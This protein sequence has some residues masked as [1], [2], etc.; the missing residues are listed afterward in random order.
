MKRH[1]I[2]TLVILLFFSLSCSKKKEVPVQTLFN[3]KE[4]VSL[5]KKTAINSEFKPPLSKEWDRKIHESRL[6]KKYTRF[7]R[8]LFIRFSPEEFSTPEVLNG[9]IYAGGSDGNF[10]CLNE[11]DGK[12]IW[13]LPGT[14]AVFGNPF[15]HDNDV[16]ISSN[17]YLWRL[18]SENGKVIWKF[19]VETEVISKPAIFKNKL[20]FLQTN[21][22]LYAIDLNN[23]EKIWSYAEEIP[24]KL[25]ILG[26]SSPIYK[27]GI[28]YVGFSNG[29]FAAINI[30]DGT[31]I[32]K[33]S[34]KSTGQFT[35]IDSTALILDNR[36]Y[37]TAFDDQN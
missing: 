34:F 25:T 22:K 14:S 9:K 28:L 6:I 23:A 11:S 36:I 37:L 7:Y 8:N 3:F 26:S 4:L 20:F 27:D 21:N 35:D 1:I 24:E 32:W 29:A 10:Y 31:E 2:F 16:F 17:G 33:K 12:V 15:I 19:P 30:N 13:K 18:N 5:D